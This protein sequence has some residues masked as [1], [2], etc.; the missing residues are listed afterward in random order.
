[1]NQYEIA[2]LIHAI[3]LLQAACPSD[4]YDQQVAQRIA[5]ATLT[6]VPASIG[7][8]VDDMESCA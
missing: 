1:M 4:T 5:A 8:L 7:K 3:R 2:S 6:M